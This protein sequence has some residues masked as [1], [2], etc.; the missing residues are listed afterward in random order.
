MVIQTQY[1]TPP[2]NSVKI[3]TLTV[4]ET[5]LILGK[6]NFLLATGFGALGAILAKSKEWKR[7]PFSDVLSIEMKKFKMNNKACYITVKDEGDFIF[8]LPKAEQTIAMLQEQ[9]KKSKEITL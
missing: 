5:E 2:K 8:K 7:I 3:G 9:L 6:K 4:T 1:F